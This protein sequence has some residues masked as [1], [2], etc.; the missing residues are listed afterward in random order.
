M[1]TKTLTFQDPQ[2]YEIFVTKWLPDGDHPVKAVV[3]IAHGMAETAARYEQF[4]KSLTEAGYIVYANDHR[5]HGRTAGD[6]ANVGYMGVDGFNQ[7][8]EDMHQLRQ[9]TQTENQSLPLFLLGHSMGSFLTQQYIYQHGAGL[10]GVILSGTSGKRGFILNIGTILARGVIVL[11]GAKT[12]SPFLDNLSF[13]SYNH[14]FKPNRTKFD[15][16]SRDE[17]EVD[18]YIADP[19]CG[20]VFSAGFFYDLCRGLRQIHRPDNQRHIPVDLPVYLFAG[21]MDPVGNFTKSI[22]HL[23]QTYHTLGIRDVAYQFYPDGRHE[24]LNETNRDE[25]TRDVIRWLDGHLKG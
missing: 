23:I 13:G 25:V 22:R 19:F 2:G 7:A 10:Q 3:Q 12:A 4:A 8:V 1:Q 9:I 24:M 21:S 15:W 18:K 16:L 11:K 5:G 17:T 6:I 20:T 14:R